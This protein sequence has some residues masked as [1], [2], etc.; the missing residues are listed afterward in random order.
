MLANVNKSLQ[1]IYYIRMSFYVAVEF[2]VFYDD[3]YFQFQSDED[4]TYIY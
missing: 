3:L 1:F 2:S 4:W